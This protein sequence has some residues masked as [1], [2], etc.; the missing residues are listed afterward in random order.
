MRSWD[1]FVVPRPFTRAIFLYGDPIHIPR[2]LADEE[3]ERYRVTIE[4]TLNGLAERGERE[5]DAL[6]S[7]GVKAEEKRT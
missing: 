3:A 7:R 6:W 2:E 5:F 1:Q 4:Q